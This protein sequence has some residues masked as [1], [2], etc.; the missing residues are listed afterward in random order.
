MPAL[1]LEDNFQPTAKVAP[2]HQHTLR[3]PRPIDRLSA[4]EL[5]VTWR[6]CHA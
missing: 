4:F 2:L 1:E 5:S 3:A 6:A